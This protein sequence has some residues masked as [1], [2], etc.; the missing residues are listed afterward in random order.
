VVKHALLLAVVGCGAHPPVTPVHAAADAAD[1]LTL[2]RDVALVR[3]RISVDVGTTAATANVRLAAGATADQVVVVDRGGLVIGGLHA[4]T[5]AHIED[6]V[7]PTK[8]LRL[9]VRAPRPGRYTFTIMY[10]T[11]RLRWDA[12]YT[13]TTTPARERAT[14]GGALAIRNATGIAWH[15]A[16]LRIIDAELGGSR[17][18]TADTLAAD[19]VGATAGTPRMQVPRELGRFDLGDGEMRVELLA[20]A[21]PRAMHSVLVYDPIGTK[22]DV[23]TTAPARD[24]ALGTR[25]AAPAN[26][27]E[28][29][30]V[31]RD[32]Q[33]AVGLPA[34]PVRLLERRGDGSLVVLGQSRLF[35]AATRAASYDTIAVGTADGITGHRERRELTIDDDNHRLVE[36][37]VITID[38]QRPLP[39][40]VVLREHLYRGL[41]W[42]LPYPLPPTAEQE[43]PQQ[44]VLRTVVP[45]HART[46]QLYVVVYTWDR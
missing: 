16:T 19:L 5:P 13:M 7:I 9:D 35:D 34:G 23:S 25:P 22:L 37:F 17:G 27:I 14:L 2:Y 3:Q 15:A 46:K 24:A 28:S 42:H 33:A 41:N 21:A 30:E 40:H 32:E 36:E 26:V 4:G 12:A 39:A 10:A 8:E 20:G 1:D 31:E 38:N 6:G 43:G 11:D 45:A 18:H 44:I 29:F